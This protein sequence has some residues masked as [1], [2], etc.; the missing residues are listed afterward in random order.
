M[1]ANSE[2]ARKL[3]AMGQWATRVLLAIGA[4]LVVLEVVVQVS[5]PFLLRFCAF[6]RLPYI[7]SRRF[8][9]PVFVPWRQL[10]RL[11]LEFCQP[12]E[13]KQ[14]LLLMPAELL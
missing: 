3:K 4:V 2:E 1:S 6:S 9:V 8:Y 5:W 11:R 7:L 13:L 12:D 14:L 10:F